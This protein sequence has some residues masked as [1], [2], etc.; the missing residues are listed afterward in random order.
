MLISKLFVNNNFFKRNLQWCSIIWSKRNTRKVY[1]GP[2]TGLWISGTGSRGKSAAIHG[3]I[4]GGRYYIHS[5][6]LHTKHTCLW[7]VSHAQLMLMDLFG[8]LEKQL[9]YDFIRNRSI[10]TVYVTND[11]FFNKYSLKNSKVN[12]NLSSLNKRICY[13][14]HQNLSI[15]FHWGKMFVYTY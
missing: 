4:T 8:D 10:K 5:L 7:R 15:D 13:T 14:V 12:F 6:Y 11:W 2:T 3:H 9:Y 1:N